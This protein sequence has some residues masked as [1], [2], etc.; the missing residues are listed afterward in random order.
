MLLPRKPHSIEDVGGGQRTAPADTV[1]VNCLSLPT[2]LSEGSGE[3]IEHVGVVM[4]EG[5]LRG[6]MDRIRWF[7][8][9]ASCILMGG[10]RAFPSK[11]SI[12]RLTFEQPLATC[13][14]EGAGLGSTM[15]S[16]W[17]SIRG[18]A[19]RRRMNLLE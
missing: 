14:R 9:D 1:A 13:G 5:S 6:V 4:A 2:S 12:Q 17:S 7:W 11:D 16:S 15:T 18:A 19:L 3:R 10:A 8:S